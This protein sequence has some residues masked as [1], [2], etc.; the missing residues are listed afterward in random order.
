MDIAKVH[1]AGQAIQKLVEGSFAGKPNDQLRHRI[2]QLADDARHESDFHPYIE[3]KA[4][5]VKSFADILYSQKKHAKYG[6][7]ERA[8]SHLSHYVHALAHWSSS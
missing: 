2:H 1:E 8:Q 4:A 5:G 7:P 3:E 6:G